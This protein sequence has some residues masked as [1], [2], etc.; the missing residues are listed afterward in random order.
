MN[1][2]MQLV[3]VVF[4][5]LFVISVQAGV[6]VSAPVKEC[7]IFADEASDGSQQEGGKTT[8]GKKTKGSGEEEEEPECD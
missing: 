2:L 4:S 3:L 8:D 1:R 7:A 5:L 6:A